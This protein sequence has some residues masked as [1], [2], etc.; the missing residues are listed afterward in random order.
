MDDRE[1]HE[2]ARPEVN[3]EDEALLGKL[4][5]FFVDVYHRYTGFDE[6]EERLPPHGLVLEPLLAR[7]DEVRVYGLPDSG[8]IRENVTSLL[9]PRKA[10][11]ELALGDS[12][13]RGHEIFW[14]A[15]AWE[16][17]SV[18]LFC[19]IE[20]ADLAAIFAFCSGP[21]VWASLHQLRKGS[22]T[23]AIS[24]CQRVV[25]EAPGRIAFLF[26]ASNGLQHM[27]VFC[28]PSKLHA[29]YE[30]AT[31]GCRPFKRFVE[32][33]PDRDEIIIDR[34]PYR[35]GAVGS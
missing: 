25:R 9:T 29:A 16:R 19:T 27:D 3:D 11:A 6:A 26:S 34:P 32:R 20:P 21:H 13:V 30:V 33:N 8:P 31:T 5:T 2:G 15:G 23:A 4:G 17:G 12:P 35:G 10:Y 14:N 7:A 28:H 24:H 1:L 22:H 18:A